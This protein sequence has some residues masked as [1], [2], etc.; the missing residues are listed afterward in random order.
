[1]HEEFL[2]EPIAGVV[3]APEAGVGWEAISVNDVHDVHRGIL[4]R[5]RGFE[6]GV[7]M[8]AG[9]FWIAARKF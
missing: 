4:V 6:G 1:M 2:A 3:K 7:K 9:N 8:S 5:C